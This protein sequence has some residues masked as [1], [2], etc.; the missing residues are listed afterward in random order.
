MER[1]I[2]VLGSLSTVI[3]TSPS[4]LCWKSKKK[5]KEGKK[6]PESRGAGPGRVVA[7]EQG[8]SSRS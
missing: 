5:E 2:L 3:Q 4:L 6:P 8:S 1:R 7:V